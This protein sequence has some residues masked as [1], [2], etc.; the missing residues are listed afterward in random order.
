MGALII[1][2]LGILLTI[3]PPASGSSA[4]TYLVHISAPYF[5]VAST[6]S[7]VIIELLTQ[8]DG[9]KYAV[10]VLP[11]DSIKLMGPNAVEGQGIFP[12]ILDFI[13]GTDY[14][15][16]YDG[17][18]NS[19]LFVGSFTP[20][21]EVNRLGTLSYSKAGGSTSVNIAVYVKSRIPVLLRYLVFNGYN[22][23]D[24]D[25]VNTLSPVPVITGYPPITLSL[26][27]GVD[28]SDYVVYE[29]FSQPIKAIPIPFIVNT[30]K[31]LALVVSNITLVNVVPYTEVSLLEPGD[32]LE[33]RVPIDEAVFKLTVCRI[34]R[35]LNY[36]GPEALYA[37]DYLGPLGV[38]VSLGSIPIQPNASG[39]LVIGE[40]LSYLNSGRF[41]I[42]NTTYPIEYTLT[43]GTGSYVD[44]IVLAMAVLRSF[45][46]PTRAALGFV[47]RPMGNGVYVYHLGGNA[48]IWVE[49]FTSVGWVPFEPISTYHFNNY[50]QLLST[51][52]YT[53][54]ISLLI[55]VPWLIGYYIYYYLSRK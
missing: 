2:L 40:L 31:S 15:G 52:L 8:Q 36:T 3:K 19:T 43:N 48:V 24:N 7:S 49:A 17:S 10:M 34:S 21:I 37:R 45:N 33:S 13:N 12:G 1:L 46:I 25:L 30:G 23:T 14:V 53:I 5:V 9:I 11:R 6:N 16:F 20:V 42:S 55:M 28:C 51:V 26:A 39:L 27:V 50:S 29:N 4:V 38:N 18:I 35:G 41:S 22:S 32:L 44:Y 54:P 47:G